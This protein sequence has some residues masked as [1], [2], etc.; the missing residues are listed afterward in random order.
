MK[1]LS[2][3]VWYQV[4]IKLSFLT[5][6]L[7]LENKQYRSITLIII[8]TFLFGASS[9]VL[10]FRPLGENIDQELSMAVDDGFD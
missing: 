3:M 2:L 6:F 7:L 10:G 9:C 5:V 8:L 1:V 4:K